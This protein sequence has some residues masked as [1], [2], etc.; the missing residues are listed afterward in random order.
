M[1]LGDGEDDEDDDEQDDEEVEEMVSA[2]SC[3]YKFAHSATTLTN[4]L[5]PTP[6]PLTPPPSQFHDIANGK[7]SITKSALYSWDEL[8]E[9]MQSGMVTRETIDSYVAQVNF[10]DGRLDLEAFRAFIRL[11]DTVLVDGEGNLLD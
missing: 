3:G 2:E 11:L 1:S 7:S 10:E 9:L 6:P 4:S 8:Q 5:S